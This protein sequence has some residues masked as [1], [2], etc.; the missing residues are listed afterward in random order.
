M[1]KTGSPKKSGAQVKKDEFGMKEKQ[2]TS[3]HLDRQDIYIY[4]LVVDV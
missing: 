3:R 2:I 4:E 1:V